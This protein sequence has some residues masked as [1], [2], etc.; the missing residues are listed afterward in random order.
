[1]SAGAKGIGFSVNSVGLREHLNPRPASITNVVT[2]S[3]NLRVLFLIP[4]KGEI[5]VLCRVFVKIKKYIRIY[6]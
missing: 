1:M 5:V 6:T 3:L 4:E 2:L